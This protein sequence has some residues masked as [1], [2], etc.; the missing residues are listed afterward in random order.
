M[1]A[2]AFGKELGLGVG[3]CESLGMQKCEYTCTQSQRKRS[4]LPDK[5]EEDM[6]VGWLMNFGGAQAHL[7]R[8]I[9]QGIFL[10]HISV[11]CAPCKAPPHRPVLHSKLMAIITRSPNIIDCDV[12][13]RAK[14]HCE[15][16]SP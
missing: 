7:H 1:C 10:P 2:Q 13:G 15:R 9:N 6:R 12:L 14:G 16:V 3:G 4:W 11:K 5:T 8:Y